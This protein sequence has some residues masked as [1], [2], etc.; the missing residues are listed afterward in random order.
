E[1]KALEAAVLHGLCDWEEC[2]GL[3][4]GELGRRP[5]VFPR[6]LEEGAQALGLGGTFLLVQEAPRCE[7]P[8]E[9]PGAREVLG[10]TLQGN[11]ARLFKVS[12]QGGL[13]RCSGKSCG[14]CA[15]VDRW[16]QADPA[17]RAGGERACRLAPASHDEAVAFELANQ[18]ELPLSRAHGGAPART[19]RRAGQALEERLRRA[20]HRAAEQRLASPGGE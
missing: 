10:E 12:E 2:S 13:L 14:F 16:C 4:R 15:G 9:R 18:R 6:G 11:G 8:H 7:D 20:T 3:R 17:H 19:S 1:E 5:M